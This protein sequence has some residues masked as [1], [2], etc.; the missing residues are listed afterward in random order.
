MNCLLIGGA[1]SVGKSKSIYRLTIYLLS[2][3][4]VD[5]TKSVPLTFHDFKAVLEGNDK[6]GKLIRLIINTATDSVDL[7]NDFKAFF[8]THGN[9]DVLISSVRDDNFWPRHDLFNIMN[10]KHYFVLEI[11]LAKITRR[12]SNFPIAL[13]W[14]EDKLDKLLIHTIKNLPFDV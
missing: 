3:G 2:H 13:T 4:F 10:L 9:Y 11:P 12:H 5:V 8:D 6:N 14:Y 1:P 7:I